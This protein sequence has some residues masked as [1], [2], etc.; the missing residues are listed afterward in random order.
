LELELHTL[1]LILTFRA[2]SPLGLH[3][4]PHDKMGISPIVETSNAQIYGD[5]QAIYEGLVFHHIVGGLEVE[6]NN[7]PRGLGLGATHRIAGPL[8]GQ[9]TQA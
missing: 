1:S 5:T 8:G 4:L 3:H 9:C 7:I 2:A 6:S